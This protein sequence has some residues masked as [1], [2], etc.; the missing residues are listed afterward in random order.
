[1]TLLTNFSANEDIFAVFWTRLT[2]VLMDAR[3]NIKQQ[4][5]TVGQAIPG[6]KFNQ[7]WT[8]FLLLL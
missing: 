7:L 5:S 8:H 4:T 1:V 3:A 2:N 6:E